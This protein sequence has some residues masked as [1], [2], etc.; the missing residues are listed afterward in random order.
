MVY[1]LHEDDAKAYEVAIVKAAE[2]HENPFAERPAGPEGVPTHPLFMGYFMAHPVYSGAPFS[3]LVLG[4][5][6]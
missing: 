4:D 2:Q 5:R 6:E 1:E 3:R